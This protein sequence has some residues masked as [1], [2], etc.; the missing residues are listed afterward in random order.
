M[1]IFL[2]QIMLIRVVFKDYKKCF[3]KE[4]CKSVFSCTDGICSLRVQITS[5]DFD[6]Q[7]K[8]VF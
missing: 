8:K 2:T 4:N 7:Q 5:D 3:I 1:A 6:S